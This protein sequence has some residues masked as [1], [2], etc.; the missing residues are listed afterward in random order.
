VN[1]CVENRR[2]VTQDR[3]SRTQTRQRR[4]IKS[5]T[6]DI[7]R[8]RRAPRSIPRDAHRALVIAFAILVPMMPGM[9]HESMMDVSYLPVGWTYD[10]STGG[11]KTA[12]ID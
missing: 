6:D 12:V 1:S 9:S 10:P 2:G 11:H 8:D 3:A 5:F 7:A 4:A